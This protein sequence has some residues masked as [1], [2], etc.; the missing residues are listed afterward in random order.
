MRYQLVSD[1][2]DGEVILQSGRCLAVES[3]EL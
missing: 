2:V 1:I 3:L